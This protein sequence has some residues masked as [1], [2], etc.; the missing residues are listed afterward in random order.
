MSGFEQLRNAR[1]DEPLQIRGFPTRHVQYRHRQI[2]N[3]RLDYKI[4]AYGMIAFGMI[5][6][7]CDDQYGAI[8]HRRSASRYS[9]G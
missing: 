4:I 2:Y 9:I 8:A 7:L 6:Y 3:S 5:T 1:N